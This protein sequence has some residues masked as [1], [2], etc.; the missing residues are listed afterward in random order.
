M[1]H[2]NSM[3]FN[4]IVKLLFIAVCISTFICIWDAISQV[5][6]SIIIIFKLNI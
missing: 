3:Y 5:S 1:K 4:L 6:E 2:Q